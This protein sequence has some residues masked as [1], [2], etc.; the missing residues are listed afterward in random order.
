MRLGVGRKLLLHL[1]FSST[2]LYTMPRTVPKPK[3]LP[4]ATR[5][6]RAALISVSV[7]LSQTPAKA[8]SPR[9]RG[10]CVTAWSACLAP[11]LQRY[12]F[13]LLGAQRYTCVNNLPR[14]VREAET[15]EWPGLEPE[16]YWLQVRPPNH[17]AT[18]LLLAW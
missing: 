5:A 9:T 10:Q 15:A 3:V 14:V 16:T 8:A 1:F 13:I 6:H 7:A 18:T 4:E 17:H 2:P 11:N 12:Q